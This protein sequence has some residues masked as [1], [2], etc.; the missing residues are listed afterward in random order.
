MTYYSRNLPH[1]H[2]DGKTIFLTWRLFGS[3]PSAVL[4]RLESLRAFGLPR[5]LGGDDAK[6]R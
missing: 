4:K 5:K 2:P 6:D 3:L 1:W